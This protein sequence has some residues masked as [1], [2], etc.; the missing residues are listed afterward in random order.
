[1][2]RLVG[3]DLGGTAIKAGV[4]TDGGE[5][6]ERREAL[7]HVDKGPEEV[8]RRIAEVAREVGVEGT[9]GLGVPGS[10]DRV[11]GRAM[12][13]PNLTSIEG[14]PLRAELERDLDLAPGS[15]L[16]ENDANAAALGE[17]WLGGARGEDHALVFTLGTGIGGGLILGGRLHTGAKGL[18]GEVG[19]INVDPQGARCT[20]GARGCLEAMASATAARR[21]AADMGLSQDLKQLAADARMGESG[22]RELFEAVGLDLGRGLAA[23]LM[24][25]DVRTYLVGGGFGATLD[26]MHERVLD[27]MLE[28]SWGH[29]RE[30]I[31]IKRTELGADAGWIG[32]ARLICLQHGKDASEAE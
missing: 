28:R 24:I 21:R 3:V 7:T 5:I 2:P 30:G 9:L 10:I 29:D 27:G 18:A 16:L 19:H 11:A 31:T 22:A 17:H 13:S 32:A 25:L 23:V 4:I 12:V 14:Y 26:L 20:C 1:M 15:V 6:L 8:V